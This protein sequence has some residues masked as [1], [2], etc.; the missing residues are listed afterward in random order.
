M[1]AEEGHGWKF[2]PAAFANE[3]SLLVVLRNH[4]LIE[5]DFR[6]IFFVGAMLTHES[7]NSQVNSHQVSLNI[8][9]RKS[10]KVTK[11][12]VKIYLPFC[13]IAMR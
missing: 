4:V 9:F 10:F 12:T 13:F 1:T 8:H 3:F 2:S 7:F 6:G 11:I 5:G